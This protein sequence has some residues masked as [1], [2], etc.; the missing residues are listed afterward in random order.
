MILRNRAVVFFDGQ[1]IFHSA[2]EAFGYN[3]ANYDVLALSEHVC[4]MK[5][6]NLTKI[7]FYTGVHEISHNPVLHNFWSKKLLNMGR[8]GIDITKRT[9]RYRDKKINLPNGQMHIVK[10]VPEEKGI[11]VRLA[12]D[13]VL[14]AIKNEYDIAIIFS[15]DQDFIEASEEVRLIAREQNRW[16]KVVSAFPENTN[17]NHLS[18]GI[19]KTDWIKISKADYDSCL[20]TYTNL[21]KR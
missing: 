12:L 19:D 10:D 11:D 5:G 7:R 2:K 17:S 13:I 20:D 21:H 8:Q 9:L 4:R 1:N 18:R 15:Q 6:W 3:D 14:L 16:I